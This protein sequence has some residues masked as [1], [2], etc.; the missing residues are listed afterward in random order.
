MHVNK[1]TEFRPKAGAVEREEH[2][3]GEVGGVEST[4]DRIADCAL[5][6]ASQCEF[7]SM[8]VNCTLSAGPKR[9]GLYPQ[10]SKPKAKNTS[11]PDPSID[12]I[13]SVAECPV[14]I[15]TIQPIREGKNQ[16]Q[17]GM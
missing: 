1:R 2:N 5:Y 10:N 9:A 3:L 16:N 14:F 8:K 11:K 17:K 13:E 15:H 6:Y 7:Y 12:R 4:L